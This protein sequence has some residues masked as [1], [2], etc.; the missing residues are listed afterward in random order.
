MFYTLNDAS[1]DVSLA[2]DL[3]SLNKRDQFH[4]SQRDLTVFFAKGEID[5]VYLNFSDPWPKKRHTKRRL[6]FRKENC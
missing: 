5:R 6:T 4:L 2:M 3:R 1:Y